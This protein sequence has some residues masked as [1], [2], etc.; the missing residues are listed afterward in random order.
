MGPS[1]GAQPCVGVV[2]FTSQIASRYHK[3]QMSRLEAGTK[4][5]LLTHVSCLSSLGP[6]GS[7]AVRAG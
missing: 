7:E 5:A 6:G 4:E 1:L 3:P 2:P